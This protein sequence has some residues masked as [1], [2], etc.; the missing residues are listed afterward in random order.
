MSRALTDHR[1]KG[2]QLTEGCGEQTSK[3]QA[4]WC[5]FW[6]PPRQRVT[7]MRP[8]L[9]KREKSGQKFDVEGSDRL[10][11][12]FFSRHVPLNRTCPGCIFMQIT[13]TRKASLKIFKASI[14]QRPPYFQP[15]LAARPRC[16]LCFSSQRVTPPSVAILSE[17]LAFYLLPAR[18]EFKRAAA[19]RA[20]KL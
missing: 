17:I 7:A 5:T 16:T 3:H 6:T 2:S 8:L 12:T 14:L 18:A 13:W 15:V 1:D 11:E 10:K 20:G 9:K 4:G 19:D